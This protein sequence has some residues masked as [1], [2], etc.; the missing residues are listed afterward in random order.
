[1]AIGGFW[2]RDHE[3]GRR[4]L[5]TRVLCLSIKMWR[6]GRCRPTV[7][8]TWFTQPWPTRNNK[9]PRFWDIS[10][11][12]C[13]RCGQGIAGIATIVPTSC[14]VSNGWVV[15]C[16]SKSPMLSNPAPH[17]STDSKLAAEM[18]LQ[19]SVGKGGQGSYKNWSKDVKHRKESETYGVFSDIWPPGDDA[20]PLPWR[21]HKAQLT[22]LDKR[23]G[24]CS[25]PHYVDRLHYDGASFW[26]KPGRLWKAHRKVCHC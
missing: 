8:T 1:M 17:P 24:R 13:S 14:T 19:L 23:M 6:P 21:I 2:H 16:G 3:V 18:I 15:G 20:G 7:M 10:R 25:W 22:E 5:A 11:H 4:V 26:I 9:T 12:H